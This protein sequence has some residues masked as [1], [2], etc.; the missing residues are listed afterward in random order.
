MCVRN[1]SYQGKNPNIMALGGLAIAMGAMVDGEIVL[2][3]NAHKLLERYRGT[4]PHWQII[5][6]AAKEVGPA[7]FYSLLIITL[8]FIPVFALEAQ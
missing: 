4:K 1:R 6:D 3:E 8:S 5:C 7:L 2:N